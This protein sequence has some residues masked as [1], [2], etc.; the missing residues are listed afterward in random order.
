MGW[1]PDEVGAW[2]SAWWN[3]GCPWFGPRWA[4]EAHEWAAVS[5]LLV[6]YFDEWFPKGSGDSA[7]IPLL[8][9]ALGTGVTMVVK[10]AD[11]IKQYG[12][13]PW[14]IEQIERLKQQAPA[15][16]QSGAPPTTPEAPNGRPAEAPSAPPAG[17][18]YRLPRELVR[19][20]ESSPMPGIL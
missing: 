9:A 14:V 13:K 20:A 12:R 15:P 7:L 8:L 2:L 19:T 17:P 5:S 18:A 3:V 10:R 11:L 16:Q 4:A 6:P 1:T